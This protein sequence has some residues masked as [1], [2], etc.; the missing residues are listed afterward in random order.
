VKVLLDKSLSA[1]TYRI[2]WDG[3]DEMGEVVSSGV[4]LYKL[5]GDGYNISKKMI[6]LK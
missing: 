2:P 6:L 4:Y 3:R 5:S 1:G